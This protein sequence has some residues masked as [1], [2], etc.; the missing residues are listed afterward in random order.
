MAYISLK[1][2]LQWFFTDQATGKAQAH[3]IIN[4]NEKDWSCIFLVLAG[5]D[6]PVLAVD[7]G[8]AHLSSQTAQRGPLPIH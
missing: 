8:G 2:S 6:V 7:R 5:D 4:I 1:T 3:S